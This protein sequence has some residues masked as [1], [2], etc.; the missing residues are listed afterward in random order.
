MIRLGSSELYFGELISM[1]SI[2]A[3][4]ESVTRE[5]I[6]NIA[7]EVFDENRCATVIFHPEGGHKSTDASN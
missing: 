4:I 1:D 7:N 3:K 2:I 6:Q 5:N